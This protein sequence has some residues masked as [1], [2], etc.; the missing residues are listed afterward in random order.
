MYRAFFAEETKLVV[1]DGK[2]YL[3]FTNTKATSV[4][5]IKV[6]VGENE[7]A[8]TIENIDENTYNFVVELNDLNS[9]ITMQAMMPGYPLNYDISLDI[10]SLEAVKLEE[11][12]QP[13]VQ[14]E[15]PQEQV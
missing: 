13:E 2:Y 9:N 7:L 3:T 5:E 6:Q 4:P 11:T 14:P 1:K 12:Q 15:T 10:D 8:T